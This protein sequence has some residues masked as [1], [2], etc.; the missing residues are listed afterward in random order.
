VVE[1]ISG[2]QKSNIIDWISATDTD[3]KKFCA[4]YDIDCVD[5]MPV[6]TYDSAIAMLKKK[7][8]IIEAKE[9]KALETQDDAGEGELL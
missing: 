7:Q 3:T 5:S 2:K 4:A 9:R 1:C 6:A 8:A